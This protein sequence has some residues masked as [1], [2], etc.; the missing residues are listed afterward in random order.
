[1]PLYLLRHGETASNAARVYAG[2]SEEPLTERG[3]AQALEAGRRLEASGVSAI[4][5]SPLRRAVETATILASALSAPATV[6]DA[7]TEMALGPWEG[8]SEEEVTRRY[9][10]EW[11]V[12]QAHP[13]HLRLPGRETLPEVL[14]RVLPCLERI[15]STHSDDAV[16]VVTHH[17]PI[18]VVTLHQAGMDLDRYRA[19]SVG[20][21]VPVELDMGL[22]TAR[23][24]IEG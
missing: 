18:R 8:L 6:E 3:R 7:L 5:S 21:C 15:R 11:A 1:M 12:W 22:P 19:A 13:S 4:Y 14:R 24:I 20:N 17:A 23:A 16:V 2:R 9:P 10:R